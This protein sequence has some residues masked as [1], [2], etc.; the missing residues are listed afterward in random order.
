MEAL[1][2]SQRYSEKCET[3]GAFFL[4]LALDQRI[5]VLNCV[6]LFYPKLPAYN[7]S[8]MRYVLDSYHDSVT[9][10]VTIHK[11]KYQKISNSTQFIKYK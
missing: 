2:E 4:P 8:S 11:R 3:V 7:I 1:N 6:S 5:K 9:F 10:F